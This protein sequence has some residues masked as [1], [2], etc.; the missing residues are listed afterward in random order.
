MTC[1][2]GVVDQRTVW[3]GGDSAGISGWDL[4]VRADPKVFR[5]GDFLLGFT[6]SFRMGQLLRYRLQA[7]EHPLS[8]P[9][10]EYLATSWVDAVRDCLKHGGWAKRDQE[11]EAGGTFLVGYR[12]TLWAV[13]D[14]YQIEASVDNMLA[15]GCG[16]QAALGALYATRSYP[17]RRRVQT[18]LEAAERL[19]AGVRAPFVIECLA[20]SKSQ[21]VAS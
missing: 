14:D 3:L 17:G 18:A 6:T 2:V 13:H 8:M 11:R 15:V 9:T 7:P 1:I 10:D 5:R 16:D 20:P 4:T 21:R 12:G 19:C